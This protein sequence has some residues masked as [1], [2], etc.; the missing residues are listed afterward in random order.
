LSTIA[1]QLKK[2][3]GTAADSFKTS[4]VSAVVKKM[5]K[6]Q[7]ANLR[8]NTIELLNVSLTKIAHCAAWSR[9][10]DARQNFLR[11]V[12]DRGSATRGPGA[13]TEKLF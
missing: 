10:N 8:V 5:N 12:T 6:L 7:R 13:R 3:L 9:A 2:F 1:L 11:G 4:D